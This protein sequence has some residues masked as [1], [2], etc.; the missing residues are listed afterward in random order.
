MLGPQGI[1]GMV[2]SREIALSIPPLIA[3][4]TGSMSDSEEIPSF[5]PDRLNPG[6]ENMLGI[7]GLE[8]SLSYIEN[9]WDELRTNEMEKTLRLME[10]LERT[11]GIVMKGAPRNRERTNVISICTE[12]IDEAEF[13]ALLLEKGGI[14]TRVGL[15]CA[16]SA[17]RSLGTF[18]R[19][20]VRFSPGPFTTDDEIDNTIKTVREIMKNV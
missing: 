4:G 11:E 8:H 20:T 1:G 13:A 14:E 10:E 17:H 16:P 2:L 3:G 19:G 5:L 12:G 7:I 18:P 15:H 9:N 6:T